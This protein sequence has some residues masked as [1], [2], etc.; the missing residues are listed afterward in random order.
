ML[1]PKSGLRQISELSFILE[2]RV[3]FEP[4]LDF[5]AHVRLSFRDEAKSEAWNVFTFCDRVRVRVRVFVLRLKYHLLVA[6]KNICS[7][8][9]SR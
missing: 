4:D 9:E 5:I 3:T 8:T 1:Y 2:S 6:T 7:Q